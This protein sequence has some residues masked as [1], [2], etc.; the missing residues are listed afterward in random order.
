M[1]PYLET[2][3]LRRRSNFN[4]QRQAVTRRS[5][6]CKGGWIQAEQEKE[7]NYVYVHRAE[8]DARLRG[9]GQ[10]LHEK[11][12]LACE[13][14]KLSF[15]CCSLQCHT[16]Q[17]D[18]FGFIVELNYASANNSWLCYDSR[19]NC[20]LLYIHGILMDF[21][22]DIFENNNHFFMNSTYDY[23]LNK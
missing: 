21:T 15:I 23:I 13:E 18:L 12:S 8:R 22:S 7:T 19:S 6:E 11:I 5:D 10:E 4:S 2:I 20:I 14:W 9:K 17:S 3:G 16:A 1:P